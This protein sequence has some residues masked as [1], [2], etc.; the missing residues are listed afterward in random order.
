[1]RSAALALAAGQT[2]GTGTGTA[3]A[4][5][6]ARSGGCNGRCYGCGH[7]RRTQ[8]ARAAQT[9]GALSVGGAARPHLRGVTRCWR[10]CA[11]SAAPRC[12]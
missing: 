6:C 9:P 10:C 1:L 5:R 12:A 3:R 8:P 4:R 11:R 7:G 2:A